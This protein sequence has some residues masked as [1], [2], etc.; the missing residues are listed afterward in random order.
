[1]AG[2]NNAAFALTATLALTA[3]SGVNRTS[4]HHRGDRDQA[5]DK[6]IHRES[7]FRL[8]AKD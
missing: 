7:P 3:K 1:M 5:K 6:T 4:D 8:A 2:A